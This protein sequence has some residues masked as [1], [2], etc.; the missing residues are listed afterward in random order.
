MFAL[1]VRALH[2]MIHRRQVFVVVVERSAVDLL[3][4]GALDTLRSGTGISYDFAVGRRIQ[5]HQ[6]LERPDLPVK[7]RFNPLRDPAQ[8]YFDLRKVSDGA[9]SAAT[10]AVRTAKSVVNAHELV[11]QSL[12]DVSRAFPEYPQ[13]QLSP[14]AS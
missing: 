6:V 3:E 2:T 5:K 7:G 1:V 11:R 10:E 8:M 14:A 9:C 12:R 4:K 13:T